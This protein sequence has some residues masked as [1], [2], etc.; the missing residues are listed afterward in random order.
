MLIAKLTD[1]DLYGGTPEYL[2]EV[3]RRGA[4]YFA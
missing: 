3:T 1:A 2:T 4:R